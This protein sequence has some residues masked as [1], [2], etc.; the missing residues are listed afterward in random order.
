MIFSLS[1]IFDIGCNIVVNLLSTVPHD[2]G[3]NAPP[4]I[5]SLE[6]VKKKMN[7]LDTLIDIEIATN[8]MKYDFS[9]FGFS[10]C[11]FFLASPAASS[12][13]FFLRSIKGSLNRSKTQPN[14]RNWKQ[15]TR[16]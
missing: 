16:P 13:I 10:F 14:S 15:T 7:L 4:L 1:F 12:S 8:L 5:N 9:L 6:E 11:N 3:H 2:F